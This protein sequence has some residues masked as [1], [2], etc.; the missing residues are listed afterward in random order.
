MPTPTITYQFTTKSHA[1]AE[2]IQRLLD[3]SRSRDLLHLFTR[4]QSPKRRR[5]IMRMTR[6]LLDAEIVAR[7][8]KRLDMPPKPSVV[9]HGE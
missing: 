4:L 7:S 9:K 2:A 5:L 1:C 6:Y 3:D 8:Q